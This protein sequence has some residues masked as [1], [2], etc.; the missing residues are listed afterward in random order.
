MAA[1][2]DLR[3]S[4]E[5]K[6][7]AVTANVTLLRADVK[8]V[9]EK[10]TNA[11][12]DIT[13]LQSTSKRLEDQVQ[14]LTV[15]HHKIVTHLE[16]RAWRNNIRVVGVPEGVEG[17]SIELFLETLITDSLRPKRLSKFFTVDQAHRALVPLPQPGALLRT[18]IARIFNFRGRD[19]IL[20][21]AR[22]HC[23]LQYEKAAGRF[24]DFT[25]KVQRQCQSFQEVK[26]V[27]QDCE[28]KYMMLFP[29]RL[30]VIM[31]GKTWHFRTWE[32]GWEWLEVSWSAGRV[33]YTA[34]G[35]G[36]FPPHN[37]RYKDWR[38]RDH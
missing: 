14:F 7:D 23:D 36:W 5:P 24:P 35:K 2:Q 9:A 22:S 21:A 3:G 19:S 38:Q 37:D 30:R 11:E 25:L 28:L 6:L 12:T 17:Q 29:A 18:I 4:L 27:L 32:E 15:E 26:K 34:E 10:V 31:E 1:I 16:W 8:E 20:Q 13:R 33:E